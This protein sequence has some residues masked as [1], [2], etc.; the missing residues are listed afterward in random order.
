ML[1]LDLGRFR[2]LEQQSID[3]SAI[4]DCASP[5]DA[6]LKETHPPEEAHLPHNPSADYPQ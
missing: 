6:T 5:R 1:R 4:F 3:V 2:A